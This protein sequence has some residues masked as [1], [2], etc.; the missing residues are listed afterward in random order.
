MVVAAAAVAE[1]AV[2][3]LMVVRDEAED[4]VRDHLKTFA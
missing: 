2:T 4:G 1:A 3:V